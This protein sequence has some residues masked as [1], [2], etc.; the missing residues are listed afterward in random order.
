MGYTSRVITQDKEGRRY[1]DIDGKGFGYLSNKHKSTFSGTPG[2]LNYNAAKKELEVSEEML[3]LNIRASRVLSI[4]RLKQLF[5]EK[6]ERITIEEA[7]EKGIIRKTDDPV[8]ELRLMGTNARIQDLFVDHNDYLQDKKRHDLLLKDAIT[9]VSQEF[10]FDIEKFDEEKYMSWFA[11][12]LGKQIATMHK[13]GWVHT[14]LTDQNITL[15]GRLVD[16]AT[17]EHFS[18]EK[19]AI[20][21]FIKSVGYWQ[22]IERAARS[23]KKFRDTILHYINKKIS[24]KEFWDNVVTLESLLEIFKETYLRN[25]NLSSGDEIQVRKLVIEQIK[26]GVEFN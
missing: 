18:E 22:D 1:R 23:L 6:G 7:K 10:G 17:A 4:I 20:E 3:K 12:N 14:G 15:D 13:N 19:P 2:I 21:K 9:I 25:L 24:D 16:F 8:V 5:N 26:Y 11:E